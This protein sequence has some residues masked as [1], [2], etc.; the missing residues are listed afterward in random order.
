MDDIFI[1]NQL[2]SPF[3]RLPG[4]VRNRIYE[5]ALGGKVISYNQHH[6]HSI[7]ADYYRQHGYGTP[8]PHTVSTLLHLTATCRQIHAE[9]DLHI[10]KY[11][12]FLINTS[13]VLQSF[14]EALSQR[15][16]SAI[17]T[18]IWPQ[19]SG[20]VTDEM[21]EQLVGMRK[22]LVAMQ[23]DGQI[24]SDFWI[25]GEDATPRVHLWYERKRQVALARIDAWRT[26]GIEIEIYE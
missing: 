20:Y 26:K 21:M 15:Q 7:D 16:L 22:I 6:S 17:R 24:A 8:E 11:N 14:V 1:C 9:T 5:Y 25:P 3:L 4:E 19:R 12:E 23:G 10:F 2:E 18:Y 13:T